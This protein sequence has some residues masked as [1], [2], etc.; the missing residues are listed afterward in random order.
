MAHI[1][2]LGDSV[3][4]N[5]KYVQPEPDVLARLQEILPTG[6]K[7]TS[8]LWMDRLPTMWQGNSP[9]C[10]RILRTWCLVSAETI[11]LPV[12]ESCCEHRSM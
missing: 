10:R 11:Y 4:D 1:I 9:I 8:G 3:F 2:L 7:A 5:L 6:W 12:L